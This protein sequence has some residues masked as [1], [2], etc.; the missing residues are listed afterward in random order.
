[1]LA[2]GGRGRGRGRGKKRA[3]SG[4]GASVERASK[5]GG[6]GFTGGRLEAAKR[7]LISSFEGYDETG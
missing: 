7:M 1:M 2:L 6:G 4:K 3:R 5:V